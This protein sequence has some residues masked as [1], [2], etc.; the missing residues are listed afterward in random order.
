V[1]RHRCCEGAPTRSRA[2][3]RR[4]AMHN[5]G[6]LR[7]LRASFRASRL[8]RQG[9]QESRRPASR[10]SKAFAEDAHCPPGLGIA[11]AGPAISRTG[12]T[13][14][15]VA[16]ERRRH[17]H[18]R[19]RFGG[20]TLHESAD[21]EQGV[22]ADERGLRQ[23]C[24][25]TLA[26]QPSVLRTERCVSSAEANDAIALALHPRRGACRHGPRLPGSEGVPGV[27]PLPTGGPR[28]APP[29]KAREPSLR[30]IERSPL[31]LLAHRGRSAASPV[32]APGSPFR[33]RAAARSR[34]PRSW[35]PHLAVW[36]SKSVAT[37]TCVNYSALHSTNQRGAEQRVGAD[38]RGLRQAGFGHARRSTQCWAE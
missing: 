28:V 2:R 34:Q 25:G 4:R 33:L 6:G 5:G 9:G 36:L 24:F 10:S 3:H 30:L 11:S 27:T 21:A 22:G 20:V 13:G 14:S 31:R 26:A 29:C 23:A 7:G 8:L 17:Q 1:V 35:D 19:G 16:S 15:V 32:A 12:S 38:E 37:N 18:V